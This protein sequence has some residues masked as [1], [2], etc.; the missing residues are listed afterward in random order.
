MPHT[1]SMLMPHLTTSPNLPRLQLVLSSV[2]FL[3]ISLFAMLPAASSGAWAQEKPVKA[4]L[5]KIQVETSAG[6]VE[7]TLELA[8]NNASRSRG[9]MFRE[10]LAP[11]NGMLFRF[12]NEEPVAMWMK[13]TLIPLDMVF[14]NS[15]GKIT[16]IHQGAVPHSLE[17]ISSNGPAKYVLEVNAGEVESYGLEVGQQMRHPWFKIPK[18]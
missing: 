5:D 18:S 9:L 16:H 3:M 8:S 17:N 7:W 13:N 6:Q 1:M 15:A 2:A 11:L 12:V 14:L 4:A 10:Q